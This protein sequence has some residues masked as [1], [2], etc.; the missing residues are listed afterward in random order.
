MGPKRCRGPLARNRA[1][2]SDSR[3]RSSTSPPCTQSHADL[4]HL[5]GVH[6]GGVIFYVPILVIQLCQGA[7]LTRP[8]RH[9]RMPPFVRKPF[10][11]TTLDKDTDPSFAFQLV[12]ET[13][14]LRGDWASDRPGEGC[15]SRSGCRGCHSGGTA[16]DSVRLFPFL[17]RRSPRRPPTRAARLAP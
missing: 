9:W 16:R 7:R 4:R 11:L 8:M 2:D 10:S 5:L 6:P 12:A 15:L 13:R 1:C 3:S 14:G 17:Q